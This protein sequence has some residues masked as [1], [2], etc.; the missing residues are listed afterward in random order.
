MAPFD[1]RSD[2]ASCATRPTLARWRE[3]MASGASR[4][5]ADAVSP[6]PIVA[7]SRSGPHPKPVSRFT[8]EG[9]R[10]SG[11]GRTERRR[12]LAVFSVEPAFFKGLRAERRRSREAASAL[13]GNFSAALAPRERGMASVRHRSCGRALS[14]QAAPVETGRVLKPAC[15]RAGAIA[16]RQQRPKPT[17]ALR[18]VLPR[19]AIDKDNI[20]QN[21]RKVKTFL[22]LLVRTRR[23]RQATLSPRRRSANIK[24]LRAERRRSRG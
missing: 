1:R 13:G 10:K 11:S 19:N 24:G 20:H 12:S 5:R 14:S 7:R 2:R 15:Q 4:V 21:T 8:G 23:T 3:R 9:R 22:I 6:G 18:E 16:F 17:M